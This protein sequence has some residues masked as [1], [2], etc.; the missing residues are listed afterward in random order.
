M[1][2]TVRVEQN[3]NR[4][5]NFG[6]AFLVLLIVPLLGIF[7]KFSFESNRWKDSMFSSSGGSGDSD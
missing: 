7:R 6:C 3:V 1:P 5:V 2:I 4:G